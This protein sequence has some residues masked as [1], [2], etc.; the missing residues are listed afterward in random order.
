MRR[1]ALIRELRRYARKRGLHFAVIADK[2]KGSHCRIEVGDKYTF[3]KSGEIKPGYVALI[4][5]QLGID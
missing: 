4:K 5:K 3:C 2:G 1:E